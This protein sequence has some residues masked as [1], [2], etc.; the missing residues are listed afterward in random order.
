MESFNPYTEAAETRRMKH[1]G[2]ALG[3]LLAVAFLFG[4]KAS[5]AGADRISANPVR[6]R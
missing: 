5:Q 3:L 4:C 6:T 1:L 2:W